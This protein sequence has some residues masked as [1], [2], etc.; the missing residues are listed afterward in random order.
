MEYVKFGRTG[1]EVSRLCIGCMTYGM[2]ER[3]AASLDPDGRGEPARSSARRS[4]SA[5]TSSTP[6]TSIPTARSEEIVGRALK[7]FA[8]RDD[9]VLATKVNSRMR[10]GPNGTGLSRKAILGEIDNSL[11]RLGTDYVDL[12]QIH[13]WDPPRRSRRRWRRCTT[14]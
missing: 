12:Y 1:L 5:S 9:I 6:P 7:D 4:S 14:W 10:P 8:R 13:R 2:P 3:G 11:R